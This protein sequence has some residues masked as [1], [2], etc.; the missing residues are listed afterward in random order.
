MKR[1]KLNRVRVVVVGAYN[2]DLVVT[3]EGSIEAGK[4]LRGAPMQIFGGGRGAN[5]AVAAARAGCTIAFVGARGRDG[6]GGMAQGQLAHES[7]NLDYFFELPTVNTGTSLSL[8][9]ACTGK[10]FLV[11]AESANDHLTPQMIHTAKDLITSA[12]LVISELEIP[13]DTVFT[14]MKLCEQASIPFVLDISPPNRINQLP[15]N[16]I[17]LGVSES[18]EE[19]M[20]IT[21]CSTISDTITKLHE[22]GCQNVVLIQENRQVFHSDGD[23][24]ETV[25]VPIQQVVDRCGATECL[26]TWMAIL[27]LQGLPLAEACERAVMAMA[28]TLSRRGGHQSMPRPSDI[29]EVGISGCDQQRA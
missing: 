29:Q 6:F 15:D 23:R 3:C 10:H 19:A 25:L 12:D 11:C 28:H 13:S 18:L 27:L 9:E 26:E 8:I 1:E 7:V 20:R 17:F 21:S 16:N 4:S 2:A 24:I 22:L 5:C 14:V